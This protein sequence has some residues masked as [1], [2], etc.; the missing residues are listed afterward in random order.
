M[1]SCS[2]DSTSTP[3]PLARPPSPQTE[4]SGPFCPQ[5][6]FVLCC[7]RNGGYQRLAGAAGACRHLPPAPGTRTLLAGLPI[8]SF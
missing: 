5:S 6:G 2:G 7:S 3:D 4:R 1:V 8:L